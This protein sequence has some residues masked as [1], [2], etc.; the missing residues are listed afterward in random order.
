MRYH[1][2][3]QPNSH[4]FT[5]ASVNHFQESYGLEVSSDDLGATHRLVILKSHPLNQSFI[6]YGSFPTLV[7]YVLC[8]MPF[9]LLAVSGELQWFIAVVTSASTGVM[10]CSIFQR[11]G[12]KNETIIV[13]FFRHRDSFAIMFS[14]YALLQGTINQINLNWIW[15]MLSSCCLVCYIFM[16]CSCIFLRREN[17]FFL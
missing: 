8:E 13:K 7:L 5:S 15:S 12:G 2:L 16:Y 14:P 11:R 1:F 3:K 10:H 6:Q 17:W 9:N 4:T